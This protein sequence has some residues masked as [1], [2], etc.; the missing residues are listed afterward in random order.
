MKVYFLTLG[1]RVNQYETDAA[2][3]LFLDNGHENADTPEE[4]D[5]C[6]VNTCSVT[7]E[8]DRKSSQMLRRMAKNNPNAVIVAMG[9][10]SEL[11]NGDVAAD[12]VIGT[13]DK[14]TVVSKVEEFLAARENKELNHITSHTRPEVSKTDTYHDFGTVLSP[15][16][17]RAFI[18]VEDGC[19]NFCTYCVIP[20]ARGRVVSRSE[21]SCIREAE[22]LVENGFKE[23]IVS[24]IHLCSYGKDQGRD[25]TALLDLLKKIDAIPGLERLRL[26]SL[27]PKSMTPEFIS[28]LKELKYL[29]P[30]FHLSLQSGSDTVLR[31]MNRKYTTSEYEDR[32]KALRAEFPDMSL[33]T[34]II[35][36]FPEET[37]AEFEE[38]IEY[39]KKLKFAKIHV[40]PYSVREGTKAA[41]MPQIDMSIRKARAKRLIEVSSKLEAEFAASMIGKEAEILIEKIEDLDGRLTAEGYTANYIRA[42]LDVSGRDLKRGDII[43]GVVTGSENETCT[44]SFS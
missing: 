4:A 18:K 26:G 6:I 10:A 17:T 42:F 9:C 24:G 39:A 3:R 33:T 32:V 25:I 28:G 14:N 19:N 22:Y 20:Y 27:E 5:V 30:H 2:R 38:T 36:G 37:E 8:A 40:F 41:D 12:I 7:G 29:C 21:E 31:R 35:T 44:L 13:R 43:R 16:G 34:D 1:C 23:I 15:E 11:K